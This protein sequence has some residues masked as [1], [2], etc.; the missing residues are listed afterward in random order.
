M[1]QS[2]T[3][4]INSLN[5]FSDNHLSVRR[6][7]TS[8]F[9]QFDNFS[10]ADNIFP[11]I[12]AVPSDVSMDQYVNRYFFR[13]YVVD[14]L[15]KDRTNE[16]NVLNDTL[17]I[18]RD[19][20]N[21]LKISDNGLNVTD[22]ARAIPVNN[23]LVDFTVGWYI[24]IEIE[25]LAESNDCS[26]PFSE[27]FI[28]SGYS[29][30]YSYA[31]Q[32]LTCDTLEDCAVIIDIQNQINNIT[33]GTG[34]N[35]FVTGGT[36]NIGTETLT[37]NRNDDVAIDISGF[38]SGGGSSFTGG[39][40][41]GPTEFL[42][43]LTSTTVSAT[44]YLN[45]PT[46]VYV[47]EG[48]Y[49]AGTT[50]FTNST[51]GT[52]EVTGYFTGGTDGIFVTGPIAGDGS[53]GDPYDVRVGPL[54][55][56]YGKDSNGSLVSDTY[57]NRYPL[58]ASHY[59]EIIATD[60][61]SAQDSIILNG[62]GSGIQI[63]SNDFGSNQSIVEIDSSNISLIS[64]DGVYNGY[65]TTSAGEASFGVL[66]V[67]GSTRLGMV[68]D[69]TD[70][71][72]SL[73]LNDGVDN[74]RVVLPSNTPTIGDVLAISGNPSSG[75]FT[76][77]WAPVT[78][79]TSSVAWGDITGNL[80]DQTDL[81]N[82]LD[83]KADISGDTF[84][85]LLGANNGFDF[86]ANGGD[87]T[88]I[89][90][91]GNADLLFSHSGS[92]DIVISKSGSGT[93]LQDGT[94][95]QEDITVPD[96]AYGPSW[97]NS[98]EAPT[99]NAIFDKIESL[100][101]VYVSGGTYSAGTAVFTNT[102]GGTFN[103]TGFTTGGT[104]TVPSGATVDAFGITIDGLGSVITSGEKG[105][106]SIPYDATITGWNIFSDLSGDCVIDVW[107]DTYDNFPPT[108]GDSIT[109]T[110]KPTLSSQRKNRNLTLSSWTTTLSVGD[111][112]GFNVE[113]TPTGTTR[114]NLII[115]IIKT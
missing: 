88:Q 57:L 71:S 15:Q 65:I 8:F 89:V 53:S 86:S 93:I 56:A 92:G 87:V 104:S 2:Y 79:G 23:F 26:I 19:L 113:E 98:L 20:Y 4:I 47:T 42:N 27:N 54:Q 5:Q 76:S 111:V 49:S 60:E 62:D 85:G 97:N 68:A 103:V 9:E 109:G 45:L 31:Q 80:S 22:G 14:I 46:D 90:R 101:D 100:T 34:T 39:T 7:K 107:K 24:D 35:T 11:I 91:S 77:E 10:T 69:V 6:F 3:T 78:G 102:T 41:T 18:L 59:T 38:T 48:T 112:I 64:T 75:V 43:G 33:G 30:S 37:L 25:G 55:I 16:A 44:T 28:F 17:L 94:E 36:F 106:I 32:Y 105:Y 74:Y 72:L 81:N 50:T 95:F 40:V 13:V 58:S 67:T 63:S 66:D 73:Q 70:N 110:E 61:S 114:V 1:S 52:F 83:G 115:N 29:C 82:A 51:G 96:E 108:S 99:K 84:T 12:Y 21:W